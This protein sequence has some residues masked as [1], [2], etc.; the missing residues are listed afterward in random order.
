MV[1]SVKYVDEVI[2]YKSVEDIVKEIDYDIFITGPDQTHQGFQNAIKYTKENG[3]TAIVLP[4]TEGISSTQIK[5][6]L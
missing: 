6:L 5:G 3:K 2:L 4:R 1:S